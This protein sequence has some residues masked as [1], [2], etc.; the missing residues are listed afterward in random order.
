M[1]EKIQ[2]EVAYAEPDRQSLK[3]LEVEQG[4]TAM[5]AVEQ[6]GILDEYEPL[7]EL[8]ELP[9][10][11]FGKKCPA[12]QVLEAG[13]RVEIYRPLLVDPKEARRLKAEAE[14]RRKSQ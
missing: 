12:D 8:D 9:L 2:V 13:D 4:T 7:K 1:T 14:K 6:S 10:G 3:I 5:S 11:I